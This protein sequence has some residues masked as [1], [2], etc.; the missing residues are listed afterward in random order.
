MKPY[1]CMAYNT[2]VATGLFVSQF[3][4]GLIHYRCELPFHGTGVHGSIDIYLRA[5]FD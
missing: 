2:C 3:A 4:K 5:P 1:P